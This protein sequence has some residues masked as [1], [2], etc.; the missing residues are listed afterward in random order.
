MRSTYRALAGLIA[1]GVVLQ[2]GFVALGWFTVL[3]DVDDGA[4]F[5]ENTDYNLGQALHSVFGLG[6]IPLLCIALL[7]VSFFA[8]IPSGVKWALIVLGVAVLQIALAV[9]SYSASWIGALHGLNAF[10]LAG[11]AGRAAR[12]ASAAPASVDSP[13]PATG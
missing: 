3:G 10:A 8:A 13:A 1:I 11:V 2:A 4:I 12:L 7:V 9:V 6:V 5:D